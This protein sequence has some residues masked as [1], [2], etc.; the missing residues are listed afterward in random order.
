MLQEFQVTLRITLKSSAPVLD[1]CPTLPK[2]Q[3]T[4]IIPIF[5]SNKYGKIFKSTNTSRIES[6]SHKVSFRAKTDVLYS[7]E[8]EW[9]YRDD[10]ES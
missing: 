7:Y 6:L 3:K 1:K 9:Y 8:P 4:H 2:L 10:K 5:T